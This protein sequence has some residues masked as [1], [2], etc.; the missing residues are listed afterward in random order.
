MTK[1]N[2]I[3]AGVVVFTAGLVGVVD[4]AVDVV[5]V[6]YGVLALG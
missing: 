3:V 2:A 4:L 1:S 6:V 5:A